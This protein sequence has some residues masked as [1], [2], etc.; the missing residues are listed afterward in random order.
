M[1]LNGTLIQ[2]LEIL[3]L[4]ENEL[5]KEI[6]RLNEIIDNKLDGKLKLNSSLS[7][8]KSEHVSRRSASPKD[9]RQRTQVCNTNLH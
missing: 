8:L 2:K 9:Q 6:E 4:R 7:S 3:D 5:L 1:N